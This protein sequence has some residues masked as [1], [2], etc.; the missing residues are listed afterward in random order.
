MQAQQEAE[1]KPPQ[2]PLRP[3]G[4]RGDSDDLLHHRH[5]AQTGMVAPPTCPMSANIPA[6]KS[7]PAQI[8]WGSTMLPLWMSSSAVNHLYTHKQL[9]T[10]P[11]LHWHQSRKQIWKVTHTLI[12]NN[13]YKHSFIRQVWFLIKLKIRTAY[14][15][16]TS[17]LGFRINMSMHIIC[18]TSFPFQAY[19]EMEMSGP[20]QPHE[21]SCSTH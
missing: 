1:L 6:S 2:L 16:C 4:T 3:A 21:V 13:S 5:S 9:Q 7:S 14:V 10:R 18:N 12:Q 20:L 19:E 15:D 11:L 8:P 17:F